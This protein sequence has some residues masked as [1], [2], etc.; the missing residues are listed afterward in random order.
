MVIVDTSVWIDS[1]RSSDPQL[2]DWMNEDLLLQHPFVTAEVAMGSFGSNEARDRTIDFL[3]GFAQLPV[4]Q[5]DDFHCFVGEHSLYGT[6]L[7][8][9][10][11]HL[12]LACRNHP[13]ARL[14]TRD[15]R[16]ANA[17]ERLAIEIVG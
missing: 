1:F 7:G 12:L 3:G 13:L 6:G 2:R 17:A 10:D 16:L 15:K 9:A 8:F 4:A 14:A 5:P 11:A